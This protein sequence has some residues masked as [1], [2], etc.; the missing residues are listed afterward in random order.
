MIDDKKKKDFIMHQND[1]VLMYV[2]NDKKKKVPQLFKDKLND[3]ENSSSQ[4]SS[5]KRY[6]AKV[7]YAVLPRKVR[8][9][10]QS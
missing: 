10:S 4:C 3:R 2:L 1:V 9:N 6:S 7:T 5:P 8:R